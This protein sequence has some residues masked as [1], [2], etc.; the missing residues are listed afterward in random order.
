MD[1]SAAQVDLKTDTD[2]EEE[3]E[4]AELIA[5]WY[6]PNFEGFMVR[7]FV[8]LEVRGRLIFRWIVSLQSCVCCSLYARGEG[9]DTSIR[10]VT[11]KKSKK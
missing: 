8:L 1:D 10:A 6:R 7:S 9:A 3:W 5:K 2:E 4:V 11:S